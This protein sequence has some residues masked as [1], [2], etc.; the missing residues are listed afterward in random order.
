MKPD[1]GVQS[2]VDLGLSQLEARVYLCLLEE[3]PA[4]GYRIAKVLGRPVSN[5]YSVIRSMGEKGLILV[6]DGEKQVCRAV[7]P[8]ELLHLL[9]QQ[10]SAR[11]Q[12]AEGVVKNLPAGK[13][14]NRVYR[15]PSAEQV[16]EKASRML[17][18]CRRVA[19]VDAFPNLLERLR[20]AISR[21]AARQV[22]VAVLAYE[23]VSIDGASVV[24]HRHAGAVMKRWP[25]QWLTMAIDAQQMLLAYLDGRGRDVHHAVWSASP[26]VSWVYHSCAYC[27]FL[28]SAILPDLG[29]KRASGRAYSIYERMIAEVPYPDVPSDI[30]IAPV[31][32]ES[33]PPLMDI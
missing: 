5:I 15:L 14:D 30:G 2:L 17:E 18:T 16:F 26:T 28:L 22:K 6:D 25:G 21:A 10:F 9:E 13:A 7:P 32:D 23:P 8:D 24:T 33:I 29:T 4:T 11:K 12:R 19:L 27:D 3:A 20:P 31:E 1:D